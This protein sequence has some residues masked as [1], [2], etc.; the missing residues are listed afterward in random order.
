MKFNGFELKREECIV[1]IGGGDGSLAL[2]LINK[3]CNIVEF[4]EPDIS[5]FSLA[6]KKLKG[7]VPT[8]TRSSIR[9]INISKFSKRHKEI[10]FIL[11]DV[12]EHIDSD[13]LKNFLVKLSLKGCKFKMIGR[14][15]NVS[16]IYGLRNSFGDS[17]HIHRFTERTLREYLSKMG[18]QITNIK[19]EPYQVTGLVSAFRMFPYYVVL[20]LLSLSFICV[21]GSFEGLFAPNLVFEALS[22][23][24]TKSK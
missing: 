8:L 24:S 22:F 13:E 11:Q 2:C 16:S 21:F 19:S 17:T 20:G 1:E 5:A 12:I 4:I 3:A 9:N 18:F 15:P 7:K 10:T 23:K 6:N 14:T